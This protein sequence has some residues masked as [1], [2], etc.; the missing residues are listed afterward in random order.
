PYD[1][2]PSHIDCTFVSVRPGLVITNPDRPP[3]EEEIKFFKQNDWRLV[4][5][6]M[7]NG[8]KEH[9]V[10]CQSSRWLS[11]NVFSITPDKI[12][13]EDDEQDLIRLLEGEYG[14][15]VLGIPYRGV[16]EFGGSLHCSTWDVR[17]R[18][19]K[20]DYFPDRTGEGVF[21]FQDT[22]QV[23]FSHVCS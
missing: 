23:E 17:R 7:W 9:P 21:A 8:T 14:F 3:V 18:G 22:Q 4:D 11:M 2:Y 20:R 15:D 12:C 6:P 19:G 16:F 5:V 10:F 13:V 1:L